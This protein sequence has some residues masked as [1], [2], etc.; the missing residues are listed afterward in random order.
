MKNVAVAMGFFLP[1]LAEFA[2]PG[3]AAPDAFEPDNTPEEARW[4]GVDGPAQTHNFHVGG[5]EDWLLF[6]TQG[7]E[8]ITIETFDLGSNSDTFLELYDE[9]GTEQRDF[10]DNSGP[11]GASVLI[12]NFPEEGFF[13]LRVTHAQGG[14]GAGTEY[15]IRLFRET[16]TMP[17]SITGVVTNSAN[18]SPI[19]GAIIVL[20]NFGNITTT[21]DENGVYLLS[22]LPP[23]IYLVE[24]SAE[25]YEKSS[26]SVQ[27]GSGSLTVENF[28]LTAEVT[29]M[30]GDVNGDNVLDAVDIQLVINDVL[31]IDIGAFSGDVSG[32]GMLD[33]VDVQSIILMVLQA[34]KTTPR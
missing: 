33:A 28:A 2:G 11:G 4:I 8:I 1:V 9:T 17:G 21:T 25:G 32:D 19:S 27:V 15:S 29:S 5:D 13:L 6:Y 10:D 20:P 18:D 31:G 3:V 22:S 16:G 26:E 24:A 34:E 23:S 14:F 7:S 12:P 30:P